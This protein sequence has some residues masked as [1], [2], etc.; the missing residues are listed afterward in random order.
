M[1]RHAIPKK[2]QENTNT[3]KNLFFSNLMLHKM[4]GKIVGRQK[5]SKIKV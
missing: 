3:Y 4:K 1:K 5:K 2:K